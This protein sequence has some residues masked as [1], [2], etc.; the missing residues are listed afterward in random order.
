MSI[1][2]PL[3]Q[4]PFTL[5][6]PVPL[7]GYPLPFFFSLPSSFPSRLP[8]GSFSWWL[9]T[10]LPS[11]PLHTSYTHSKQKCLTFSCCLAGFV[12]SL[13]LSTAREQTL[14]L[15]PLSCPHP[16]V[17]WGASASPGPFPASWAGQ[18][19]WR[20]QPWARKQVC[21]FQAKSWGSEVLAGLGWQWWDKLVWLY[22]L[23]A[24]FSEP[25]WGER[26][27]QGHFIIHTS[28]A[29]N[30][31]GSLANFVFLSEIRFTNLSLGEK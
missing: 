19:H 28:W 17:H 24:P 8:P 3:L 10:C 27:E 29:R 20:Q 23:N 30:L 11:G 15:P 21:F 1:N 18:A 14:K 7:P 6:V 26:I 5:P 2:N 9:R 13:R 25:F 31:R 22:P 12:S 4:P 16:V